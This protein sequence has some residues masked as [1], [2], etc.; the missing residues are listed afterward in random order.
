MPLTRLPLRPC[1]ALRT[2]KLASKVLAP[3]PIIQQ[4]SNCHDCCVSFGLFFLGTPSCFHFGQPDEGSYKAAII[5]CSGANQWERAL[6]LFRSFQRATTAVPGTAMY[7]A[8]ITACAR[9]LYTEEA[10]ALFREMAGR[11]VPRDEVRHAVFGSL[12]LGGRGRMVGC[13]SCL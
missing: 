9:G 4:R 5:A 1:R 3:Q 7:N 12:C 6:A 2:L 11:G 13:F 10:L 8:V